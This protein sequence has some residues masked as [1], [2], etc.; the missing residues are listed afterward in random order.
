MDGKAIKVEENDKPSFARDGR[1]RPP[2]PSRNRD[3]PRILRSGRR[4]REERGSPTRGVHMGNVLKYKDA[5]IGFKTVSLNVWKCLK[6]CIYP[7]YA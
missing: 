2:L 1:R 4:R 5:V 6:L 3:S 7:L